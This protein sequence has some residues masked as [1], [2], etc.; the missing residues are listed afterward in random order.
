MGYQDR[1]FVGLKLRQARIKANLSQG[2]L[3]E[4]VGISEKHISNIERGQNYPALDTFFRMLNVLEVSI[5]DFGVNV[6]RTE[7]KEREILM[8][9]VLAASDKEVKMYNTMLNAL[10]AILKLQ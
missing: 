2:Q 10:S 1:K 3:A 6:T 5:D 7:N 4:K 9:K 8:E